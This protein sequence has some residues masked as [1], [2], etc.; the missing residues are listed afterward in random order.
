MRVL[1]DLPLLSYGKAATYC[2][3]QSFSHDSK[4]MSTFDTFDRTNPDIYLADLG[5]VSE[6][7]LKNIEE[8]PQ[9]KV[10]FFSNDSDHPNKAKVLNRF[11][12]L[13]NFHNYFYMADL[14]DFQKP[15]KVKE[16]E[17]E[18]VSL[19]QT[20]PEDILSLNLPQCIRFRIFNFQVVN[21]SRYCG[22]VIPTI[23]KNIYKSSMISISGGN[24][25]CNSAICDCYPIAPS[26]LEEILEALEKDHT[27]ELEEIKE[28]VYT[29]NNNFYAM[30]EV[31]KSFGYDK[32][33]SDMINK[34]KEL[35]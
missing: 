4:T 7:T 2:G 1:V 27:K 11:G 26:S 33:A 30:S 14:I 3:I 21:S 18:I 16:Y 24:E 8:R 22:H 34:L 10:A 31:L 15:E 5:S 35:R 9:L 12:D 6:S 29:T 32:E 20:L 28:N 19:D 25:Y 23:K 13:Y 17:C